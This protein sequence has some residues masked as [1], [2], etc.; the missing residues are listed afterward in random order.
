MTCLA[1]N[2]F[3]NHKELFVAIYLRISAGI[4]C[5]KARLHSLPFGLSAH[6]ALTPACNYFLLAGM[7]FL[8]SGQMAIYTFRRAGKFFPQAARTESFARL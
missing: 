5:L 1:G 4:F 7:Q 8:L 2:F 6:S 3:N